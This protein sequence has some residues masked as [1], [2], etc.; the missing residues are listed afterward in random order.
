[1][2]SQGESEEKL[3]EETE[4]EKSK[5]RSYSD[6]CISKSRNTAEDQ[7]ASTV[8]ALAAYEDGTV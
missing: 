6:K 4:E 3:N 7:A 5:G 2:D 8:P 1:M